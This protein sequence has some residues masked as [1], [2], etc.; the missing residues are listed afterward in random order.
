MPSRERA[1]D[2]IDSTALRSH[3]IATLR[4]EPTLRVIASNSYTHQLGFEKLL[5]SPSNTN[6][7]WIRVHFWPY[8]M[9]GR[10][11]DIHSHCASFT[12]TILTGELSS[13]AY[14]RSEIGS[15]FYEYEYCFDV[16]LGKSSAF[17]KKKSVL[18][19]RTNQK[20]TAGSVY[21]LPADELHQT[22]DVAKDTV[23][24]SIW[25][26]RNQT[27]S[28]FRSTPVSNGSDIR[29]SGM[30]LEYAS[31]KLQQIIDILDN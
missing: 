19:P 25:G 29:R 10:D 24:L 31:T 27:A 2:Q 28:V 26:R 6:L 17:F 11:T 3:L 15:E 1:L 8:S 20:F 18:Q 23:T 12:S 9:S 13:L 21:S 14:E 16:K 22:I 5:L 30:S 7:I 4:D